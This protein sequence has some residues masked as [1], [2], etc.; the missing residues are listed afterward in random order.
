MPSGRRTLSATD[1]LAGEPRLFD[2]LVEN[3]ANR[4]GL[5]PERIVDDYWLIRTLHAWTE[6][7]GSG[8]V[9]R[10]YPNPELS[11]EENLV[12][13]FVFGGGTSLSAAWG[14]TE[15]WSEDI[16]FA[17][18]PSAH[19]SQKHLSQACAEAFGEAAL[20]LQASHSVTSKSS[21][22]SFASFRRQRQ[23]VSRIDVSFKPPDA[24]P[25][26]TQHETVMSLIGRTADD[27]LLER[28]PELGGFE[29]EALGPGATA[30]DKLLA[31]TR[32]SAAGDTTLIAERARDVYDLACIALRSERFEGHIGRDSA[33]L[34]HRAELSACDER[35]RRPAD[36]FASLLS[37]TPGTD[38][39][40]ALA[41]GY[42][43]VMDSMVWGEKVPLSAAIRLAV[44]LD[45]GPAEPHELP[46][47]GPLV[48]Y[49][50]TC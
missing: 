17:L 27:D 9:Q 49:P 41:R 18:V 16:D 20:A 10:R 28:Y 12:G 47:P 1:R 46:D 50:L 14:I 43:E 21:V 23:Q 38:E 5:A 8:P 2:P 25:S 39:H 7:V 31:Q 22:H 45:P 36:G 44:S 34:L 24:A 33:D 6:A 32:A 4:Y 48:A 13:R 19:A 35:S 29:I 37:F 30:M 42:E 26:W 15:R 40:Q 11:W 3:A